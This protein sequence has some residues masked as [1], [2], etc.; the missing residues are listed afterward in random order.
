MWNKRTSK[1]RRLGREFVLDVKLRSSQVRAR[2][3]RMAAVA[4][5][6]IFAAV[7]AVFLGWRAT[8]W[9]LKLLLY[10][11]QVFAIQNIDAQSDGVIAPQQIR[12]WSG[13]RPGQNLFALDLAGVRRNLEMV[14]MIQ[15]V[16]LEKIL[17]S[18][19]FLRVVEREPLGQLSIARPRASG[20][21]EMVTYYI[22]AEAYVM[23][24]LHP[25]QCVPGTP[26]GAN[27]DLPLIAGVNPNDVVPGRALESPQVR[28]ALELI[29]AFQ[30]SPMQELVEIKRV[31]VATPEVLFARTSQ[32]SDIT[33]GLRDLDR[34]LLRWHA[35]FEEGQ[36]MSKALASLDLAVSNSIPA[37]WIEASAVPQVSAKPAKLLR[38]RKK[39]V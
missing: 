26:V 34:Q 20:G 9:A 33:F 28:G 8:D 27:D 35:I 30:R 22:D 25:S 3:F 37:T 1:N 12:R 23:A 16:S 31:D 24:P 29:Q 17:P 2:R 15:S 7:A 18:T 21:F 39:H 36:K 5:G 11:N 10:E 6:S 13:V 4:L 38:N 19:L 14:S 32:A